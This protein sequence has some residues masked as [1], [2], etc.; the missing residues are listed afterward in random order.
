MLP[1]KLKV[2]YTRG[3]QFNPFMGWAFWYLGYVGVKNIWGY[4][5]PRYLYEDLQ[6]KRFLFFSPEVAMGTTLEV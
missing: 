6:L 2:E 1:M 4:L 5:I 3:C